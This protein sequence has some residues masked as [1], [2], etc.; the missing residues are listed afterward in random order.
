MGFAHFLGGEAEIIIADVFILAVRAVIPGDI[1]II[2]I[3]VC[4]ENISGVVAL[5]CAGNVGALIGELA[6]YHNKSG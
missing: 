1:N 3:A 4:L 2:I 6:H 5:G